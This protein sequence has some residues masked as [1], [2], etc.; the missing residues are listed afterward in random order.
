M[1]GDQFADI[2]IV[3]FACL[4]PRSKFNENLPHC[5]FPFVASQSIIGHDSAPCPIQDGL[6]STI[7]F[8]RSIRDTL[9]ESR[10]KRRSR[11]DSYLYLSQTVD[12]QASRNL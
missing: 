9:S 3:A 5:S 1:M 4:D 10:S 11:T 12:I 2:V 6:G 8:R 7:R